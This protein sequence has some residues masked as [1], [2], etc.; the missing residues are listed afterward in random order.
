MLKSKSFLSI[1]LGAGCVKVA[2]FDQTD[3]GSLVLKKFGQHPLGL[4]GAQD[5]VREGVVKKALQSLITYQVFSKFVKLPP[6]DSSKVTQ[7]IQY[8]AQQNVP[9]PLEEVVW[10]YQIMGTSPSGEL[11][12][13]LV[14]IKTDLVDKVFKAAESHGMVLN[15]VDVSQAA[16]C[17]AFRY[18]YGDLE[19]CTML[20]DIGAKSSNLL[21][22][23]KGKMFAR[24]INV[25]ANS[26]TQEFSTEAKMRFPDAEKFKIEQGFVSL[27]GAYEDPDNPQQA[28]ISKIARQVMTR[29]H[30]QVNQTMQFYRTQQGGSAPDRLFL[31][32][33]ASIMPYTAQFF[34]EKLNVEVEYF[35][36][37]RAVEID[38]SLNLED[39]AR[40]AHSFGEVVGLGL[41]NVV[42]CPVELNL[43]PKSSLQ[44]QEFNRKKPYLISSVFGL[45]LVVAA[46]GLF[47][48]QVFGEKQKVMNR[49][50]TIAAPLQNLEGQLK[51]EESTLATQLSKVEAFEGLVQ[52]RFYWTDLLQVIRGSL[53]EAESEAQKR[54]SLD[55]GLWLEA[56]KPDSPGI[57][58][59]GAQTFDDWD[60][61]EDEASPMMDIEMMK[62]YG[63]LPMGDS[64]GDDDWDDDEDGA[65][66]DEDNEDLITKLTLSCRGVNRRAI[67]PNANNSLAFT[68]L[69][70]LQTQT[71]YF[72]AD[73]TKLIGELA[74]V[75]AEEGT[76]K[77]EISLKLKE[78][79]SLVD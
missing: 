32:G 1:D 43:M 51:P 9:F 21:F 52:Q 67:N 37:F 47:Y 33:G 69:Q 74:Q 79:I 48:S 57:D 68:L 42:Q 34:A 64:G 17:N 71:N 12:V 60:D 56:L 55:A 24:S 46:I 62:R 3:S 25:G 6:V 16:I 29:L 58:L 65:T 40:V 61:D 15:L 54:F 20:L 18:N 19:G 45:V 36:P 27:G 10:D 78:P 28:Q 77:F 7:I 76:F 72:N 4:P 23:E 8:E 75:N 5:A 35:N 38:P 44:R 13:L 63:L 73:D 66:S 50:Q 59:T 41:R 30:I 49:L 11:E 26:I 22:F 31:A 39:L 2:E 14:A 53:L 70:K